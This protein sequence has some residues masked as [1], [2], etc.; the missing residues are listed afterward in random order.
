M[1]GFGRLM[2]PLDVLRGL[3]VLTRSGTKIVLRLVSRLTYPIYGQVD[4]PVT[5]YGQVDVP[6]FSHYLELDLKGNCPF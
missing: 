4:V 3:S 5:S 1:A 2:C 6:T